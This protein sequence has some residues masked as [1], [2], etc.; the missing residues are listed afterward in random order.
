MQ[1]D[2]GIKDVITL[3]LKTVPLWAGILGISILLGG[4]MATLQ[5]TVVAEFIDQAIAIVGGQAA[6]NTIY[7]IIIVLIIIIAYFWLTRVFNSLINIKMENELR[8][9]IRIGLTEKRAKLAYRHI[10]NHETWD[11]IK[12]VTD[13]PENKIRGAYENFI[14]LI[15]MAVRV[16]G[17]LILLVTNVWWVPLVIIAFSIPL[18]SL[19]IK[20]GK[21]NYEAGQEV[22]KYK[23]KYEYL[24]EVLSHRDVVE[25]RTIF[26]YGEKLTD[27]WHDE[28]EKARKHMVKTQI[29]WFTKMKAGSVLT[30]SI[31]ILSAVV[32]IN[33]VMKGEMSIGL[34]MALVNAIFGLVQMMSWQFTYYIDEL[35][36]HKEYLKELSTFMGLEETEEVLAEP[37]KEV[38][39]INEIE[40]RNVTFT[41]PGT[42]Q[43]ILDNLSLKL[44][45]GSHYAVVGTNGSGKTTLTKLMTGL[46]PEYEGEIF[47]NGKELRKYTYSEL[48]SLYSVVYQDFAKYE[49]SFEENIAIGNVNVDEKESKYRI[50]EVIERVGLGEAVEKLPHGVHTYLGKIK[51]GGQDLSGGQW[52]RIA[53]ARTLMSDAP[54]YILDEPTAA[55]DPISESKLYE[56]FGRMSE[57]KTTLFISHR[58]GSTQLADKILVIGE[59]KVIE[60]GTHAE[61]MEVEGTYAHMYESQRSWYQ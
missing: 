33:P 49:I 42:E 24:G 21:A 48:K 28:F 12:R 6:L 40:F 59:G 1:K 61:L 15:A 45:Q 39:P 11:L 43:K 2:Y 4:I 26:G 25:E 23:R 56:E 30:A 7:P 37:S 10:E 36:K 9:T 18:F 14:N 35:S 20:S 27:Q 22:T 8:G 52:Q 44:E 54:M 34:F 32:M 3:P 16:G 38:L 31:S 13:L 60:Q 51:E 57:G 41:Y 50:K 47:I 19:A 53:M 58:L 29:V 17:V 46:Y 5:I 55:L